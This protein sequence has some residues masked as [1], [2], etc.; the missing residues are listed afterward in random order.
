[1][2][3]KPSSSN[4]HALFKGPGTVFCWL[5]NGCIPSVTK[6]LTQL[7]CP[8]FLLFISQNPRTAMIVFIGAYVCR[9]LARQHCLTLSVNIQIKRI[10][11]L[12]PVG[13]TRRMNSNKSRAVSNYSTV[14][15]IVLDR[16]LWEAGVACLHKPVGCNLEGV[17]LSKRLGLNGS[18]ELITAKPFGGFL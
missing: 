2:V 16:C 3:L 15:S 13:K 7:Q 8:D 1:M 17:G 5:T 6:G 12:L 18:G 11:L 9:C 10:Q 4:C 14:E